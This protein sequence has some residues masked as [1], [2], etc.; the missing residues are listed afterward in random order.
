[1]D[2]TF[3]WTFLRKNGTFGRHFFKGKIYTVHLGLMFIYF[4]KYK[5]QNQVNLNMWNY[6]QI[7][8]KYYSIIHYSLFIIQNWIIHIV[9]FKFQ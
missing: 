4:L 5:N 7:L 3:G 2:D 6:M 9:W 8:W 1:M